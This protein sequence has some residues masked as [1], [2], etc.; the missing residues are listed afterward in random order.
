MSHVGAT[1]QLFPIPAGTNCNVS[2]I[3]IESEVSPKSELHVW[4]ACI[5][6]YSLYTSP[7]VPTFCKYC[8][9]EYTTKK[10]ELQIQIFAT[11]LSS[12][13]SQFEIHRH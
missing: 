2:I 12:K 7:W 4:N 8:L 1:I 3:P 5:G 10:E 11:A 13:A 9:F 6:L